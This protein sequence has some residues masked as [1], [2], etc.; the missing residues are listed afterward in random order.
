MSTREVVKIGEKQ[1]HHGGTEFT[2]GTEKFKN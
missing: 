2:E 1:V